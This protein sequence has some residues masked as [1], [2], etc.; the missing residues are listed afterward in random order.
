[1]ID[2]QNNVVLLFF[3]FSNLSFVAKTIWVQTEGSALQDRLKAYLGQDDVGTGA[4]V[5]VFL[6]ILASAPCITAHNLSSRR[7][8]TCVPRRAADSVWGSTML[9]DFFLD[10][11]LAEDLDCA[12]VKAAGFRVD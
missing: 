2:G 7:A 9:E 10:A 4:C 12:L 5:L 1:V 8:Q 11:Y 6:V 3:N